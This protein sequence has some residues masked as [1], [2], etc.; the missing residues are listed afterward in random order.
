MKRNRRVQMNVQQLINR[1]NEYPP[2]MEVAILDGFNG[3]GDPRTINMGPTL[4]SEG[5]Y[6]DIKSKPGTPILVMGYG[7]Y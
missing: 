5:D 2:D 7:S 3:G 1:L 4:R 6:E